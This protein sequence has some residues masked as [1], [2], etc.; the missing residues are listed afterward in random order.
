MRRTATRVFQNRIKAMSILASAPTVAPHELYKSSTPAD[1][2]SI[3]FDL[4]KTRFVGL[5]ACQRTLDRPSN[6]H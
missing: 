5:L 3:P 2:I 4:P 1:Y 6:P